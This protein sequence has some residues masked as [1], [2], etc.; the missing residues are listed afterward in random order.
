MNNYFYLDNNNQQKGPVSPMQ[1]SMYGINANTMVWCTGMAEWQ[2]A[3]SI[4]ELRDFI[5][6]KYNNATPPPSHNDATYN[7]SS[8]QTNSE[9]SAHYDNNTTQQ[10]QRNTPPCPNS[11]LVWAIL[12]T[13]FCCIPTGIVA[14]V[15]ASKVSDR[16][17]MGNMAGAIEASQKAKKWSIYGC[18]AS[19]V[20]SILYFL[21]LLSL[22]GLTAIV[23]STTF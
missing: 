18:I 21:L 9:Q 10:Q 8:Y 4:D 20:G 2:R 15:Y 11:N 17:V 14:I 22:G 3:G 19:I 16:Y 23:S 6:T 12:S 5:T 1:F 7:S 13:I